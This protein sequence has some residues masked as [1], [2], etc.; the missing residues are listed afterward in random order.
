MTI[1]TPYVGQLLKIKHLL[2]NANLKVALGE[3]DEENLVDI[4]GEDPLL[5]SCTISR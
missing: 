3:K 1:V 4:E 2:A 5:R